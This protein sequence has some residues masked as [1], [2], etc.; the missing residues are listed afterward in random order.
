MIG[1][2]LGAVRN[3]MGKMPNRSYIPIEL[4]ELR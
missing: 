2:I 3:C 1:V 4:F